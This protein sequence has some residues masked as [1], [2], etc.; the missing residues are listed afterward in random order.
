[1]A[2][3]NK[4][5][6]EQ[7]CAALHDLHP[8]PKCELVWE[9]QWQLIMAIILSA[10]STDK[11]V[12]RVTPELFKAVPSPQKAVELGEDGVRPFVKSIN[13]FNNKTRSIVSLAQK[14]LTDFNGELPTDFDTLITLPGIGRKT[15]SVFLNVAYHK[16]FI[17]VD[18]HVFRLAHR[19]KLCTGKTP[20]EVQEKLEKIIP[21][22]YKP[23]FALALVLVG[24]Y[25][26][27]ARKPKCQE[28]PLWDICQADEKEKRK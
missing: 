24:R 3:L 23:D 26:C 28:C 19:L 10:Q 27:Q 25:I 9:N 2:L 20:A 14:L 6:V 21:E 5:E 12:N 4:K 16:P 17:G 8:E 13:Y 1:M 18:T 7:F 11:N 22:K 15:A